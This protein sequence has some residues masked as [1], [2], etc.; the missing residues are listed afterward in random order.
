MKVSNSLWFVILLLSCTK[1][2]DISRN[3]RCPVVYI[4]VGN[5]YNY[6]GDDNR[7]TGIIIGDS[8][9]T[10]PGHGG[11]Y[12]LKI[13]DETMS[14]LKRILLI[15]DNGT[16]DTV[17][18]FG[19]NSDSPCHYLLNDTILSIEHSG[20]GT[21]YFRLQVTDCYGVTTNADI[22]LCVLENVTPSAIFT[23]ANSAKLHP[24]EIT[25]DATE[26]RDWQEQ[27]LGAIVLYEYSINNI[28]ITTTT[29]STFKYILSST[30]TYKIDVRVKDNEDAWSPTSGD[31]Y[32]SA[33]LTI[34]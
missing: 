15:Q 1:E 8:S 4:S 23:A 19:K 29:E 10:F 31:N 9:K 24:Y 34:D 5:S 27:F 2:E 28:V 12:T 20:V 14:G 16:Y 3:N 7:N 26:S 33:Y 11:E 18:E 30:G 21:H 17:P 32:E 13:E 25:V 22:Y 6:Y